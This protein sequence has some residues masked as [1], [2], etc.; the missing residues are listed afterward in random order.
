MVETIQI[1][2]NYLD[3]SKVEIT[4]ANGLT[5]IHIKEL[6]FFKDMELPDTLKLFYEQTN[7][8]MIDSEYFIDD[9][10]DASHLLVNSC[11]NLFF[12][13]K[14]VNH[15]PDKRFILFATNDEEAFYLLDMDN[16]NPDGNPLILLVMPDYQ[17]YIPI[18]NSFDIFLECGCL[19]LLG[20]ME[21]FGKEQPASTEQMSRKLYKKNQRVLVLLKELFATAKR[22]YDLIEL[23]HVP[24]KTKKMIKISI[25][26]WFKEI[27]RLLTMFK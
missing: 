17:I 7:G 11:E 26:K 20:I 23:W 16:T 2:D 4:F 19:G 27:Q 15:L 13:T 18:T 10:E 25:A 6:L 8:L 1:L 12:T 9:L 24:E 3:D 14:K 21:S 5:H 22:E